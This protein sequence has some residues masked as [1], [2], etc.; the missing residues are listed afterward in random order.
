MLW[1]RDNDGGTCDCVT[2]RRI[3]SPSKVSSSSRQSSNPSFE[4]SPVPCD[5]PF[6]PKDS[7]SK[8]HPSSTRRTAETRLR[9][10]HNLYPQ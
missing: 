10:K 9:K 3:S 4:A 5:Q 2:H 1:C 6:A 8:L 7:I